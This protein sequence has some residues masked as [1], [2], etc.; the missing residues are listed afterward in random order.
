MTPKEIVAIIKKHPEYDP[1]RC[2]A[3]V[4]SL[5]KTSTFKSL[6]SVYTKIKNKEESYF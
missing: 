1:V 5:I 4:D 6:V 2:K 3:E